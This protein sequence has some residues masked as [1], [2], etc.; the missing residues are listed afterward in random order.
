MT[1]PSPE[2]LPNPG[3]EPTSLMSLA[4][5]VRFFNTSNTYGNRLLFLNIGKPGEER[6]LRGNRT[7]PLQADSWSSFGYVDG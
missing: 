1:F 6:R 7:C 3:I 4:L 2:D 5:A